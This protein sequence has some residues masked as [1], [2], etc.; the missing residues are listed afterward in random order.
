MSSRPCNYCLYQD[1]KKAA[2]R[3]HATIEIHPA[4]HDGLGLEG[5][6]VLIHYPG[7]AEP[8]WAV[9]FMALPDHCV[10]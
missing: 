2:A 9:W 6:D 8:T 5:V 10:C 7:D 3:C 1:F 4:A